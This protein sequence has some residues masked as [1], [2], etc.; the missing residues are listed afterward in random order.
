MSSIRITKVVNG[1]YGIRKVKYLSWCW[2]LTTAR[3]RQ[4]GSVPFPAHENPYYHHYGAKMAK[5][6]Y[7]LGEMRRRQLKV[8]LI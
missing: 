4:L 2:S 1:N 3:D 8:A 5:F 7:L 6:I